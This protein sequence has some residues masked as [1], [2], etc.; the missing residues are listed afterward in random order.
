MWIIL[1]FMLALVWLV[2]YVG[3]HV[4]SAGIHVLLILAAVAAV[5]QVV[6]GTTSRP[7]LN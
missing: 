4:A 7:R 5:M 3:F 6:G 2:T 1:A